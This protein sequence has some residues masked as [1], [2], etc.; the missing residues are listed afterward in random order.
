MVNGIRVSDNPEWPFGRLDGLDADDFREAAYE[1]FF[2]ACRSSPG[3][4]GRTAI[5]YYSPSEGGDGSGS[6]AGHDSGNSWS[7]RKVPGQGVGMA[8]TSRVKRALGLKMLRRSPSRR[9]NSCGSL[10]SSPNSGTGGSPRMN[11]T[12]PGR[13]RRPMTSAEIM[14]RQMKVTEQSDNRLRKTLMRTLVGQVLE[15]MNI[16]GA[17][18]EMQ[19]VSDT[20]IKLA[21]VTEE[22]AAK[23]KEIFSTSL[24]KWHP[25][26]V[27][28]AAVTLHTCYG[29]LLKQYLVNATSI[30][31]ETVQVLERAGKLENMLVQMVV[32]DSVECEDGGKAIV[33]EMVP[34]E[35]ESI[36][37]GLV[38]QWIQDKV[39]IGRDILERAKDTETWNPKSK[40]E[41]Y[42]QSA[43]ELMKQAKEAVDNFFELPISI[44]ED[45]VHN[46][47]EGME[48][49]FRDYIAFV[50]SCGSKQNYVPTLPPLTRCSQDSRFFKL[51]RTS[52]CTIGVYS[53]NHRFISNANQ[54][55]PSTSRGTQRLYIRLNTLHYVLS[56]LHA[57]DKT[58]TLNPRVVQ[59]TTIRRSKS[60]LSSSISFFDQSRTAI[61]AAVQ[62]VSEASAYRLVFLDSNYVFYG[63]LYVEDVENARIQPVL[64]VLKQNLTLLCAIVTERAQPMAIKEVMK[65]TFEAYLMVLLAGG[66]SRVFCRS[67][68][69]MLEEDFCSLKKMFCTCGEGMVVED[70]VDR[71]AETVEG[72]L[73]LMSQSTEQL[74]ED[75]NTVVC[76]TGQIGVASAMV[77]KVSMPPTTGKWSRTDPNTVLRVLCYRNDKTANLFLK[78]TFHLAKRRG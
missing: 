40:N 30:T 56:Q 31:S 44:T 24:K 17:T 43:V 22:L 9:A 53:D 65:A 74:I 78:K 60:N 3:F 32:E 15:D 28:V 4:G 49:V 71:E 16:N 38:R 55:R 12:V 11:F 52:S 39:K 19:Q 35:V 42:A 46:L 1:I 50:E 70:V 6:G 69:H 10:P 72:V 68:H 25:V 37:L 13:G 14:R 48:H 66:S 73:S 75:F 8:V 67:D 45:L 23:E 62:H 29:T 36:I 63:S 57:M 2:T 20:L 34:Y 51:W 26:A 33:R 76:E 61:R 58:L 41:P 27:G 47:A 54:V 59:S 5:T 77:Q 7:P 21:N 64:R 18:F